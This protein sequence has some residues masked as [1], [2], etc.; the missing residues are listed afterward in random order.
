M[1]YRRFAAALAAALLCV[2]STAA[3]AA[4]PPATAKQAA[5]AWK[6]E[7]LQPVRAAALDLTYVR[8]DA[9][10]NGY[11][12]VLLK[13]VSVTPDSG[14]R[15]NASMSASNSAL[16][17][18]PVLA[19][20][21]TMVRE[22]TVRAL[23]AGGYALADA[24]GEDVAELEV[25]IVNL[26]LI[27]VDGGMSSN[28]TVSTSLGKLALVAAIRDSASG[29]LVLRA[30]DQETGPEPKELPRKAADEAKAW[31]R[32]VVAGWGDTLKSG[33]DISTGKASLR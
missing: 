14:W 17:I 20:V 28:Q 16:N 32:Q 27:A 31:V 7:G 19:E 1:R 24:P 13:S 21:E 11:R 8:K 23:Q 12:R 22:E 33:L 9:R 29:D 10:L 30:F 25:S 18:K 6:S 3:V 15:R 5:D 4:K 2:G 26:Y